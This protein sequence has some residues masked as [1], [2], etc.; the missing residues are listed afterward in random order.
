MKTIYPYSGEPVRK[1]KECDAMIYFYAH[2]S[3]KMMPVNFAT[4]EP[5]WFDCVPAKEF[6]KPKENR[7]ERLL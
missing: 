5:H 3:G 6:R 1:C 7:Q 4:K 2:P